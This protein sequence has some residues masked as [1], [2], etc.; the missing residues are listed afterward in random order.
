MARRV[1]PY[2]S[3]IVFLLLMCMAAQP[4]TGQTTDS[5]EVKALGEIAE[6]LGKK[7]WNT[8]VCINDLS[9]L[10]P[11]LD[12]RP[13]DNNS[14]FCNC[15]YPD[16]VCHVVALI[17]NRQDLGGVLPRSLVKLHYLTYLDLYGN[18]LSHNIPHEWASTKLEIL[19][20]SVNNL[21]GPIPS[22]LGNITTLRYMNIENNLFSGMVPL[23]L[24][25]LVNLEHL[26]L[27]ANNLSG[28]LPVAL[29]KLTKLTELRISS[30]NFT[31][32]MP[33]FF[34]SWKQLE[35]LEIQASGF[36]GPIPPSI[37]I[38][39]N[40]TEL[41]ISDLVGGD[42]KFPNLGSST[43]MNR[44]M[45]KSC[46]I[47][48]P[49]PPSILSMTQ[50]QTLDLSFNR[51]DGIIPYFGGLTKLTYLCLTS[52]LLTGSVPDWI[53]SR[54]S[55]YQID[56]SYNN[57]SEGSAPTCTDNINFFKSFSGRDKLT[58]RECLD[59]SPCQ[60]DWYS[61][62]INC[63]GKATKIGNIN[64]EADVD[65]AGAAKY[66][67]VR[68]YWGFS[69]SGRFWDVNTT[70]NDYIANNVSVLKMNES[71]LYTS[72]RLSP[73][74]ITYYARCLANGTYKLKLHFAE[75]VIR[76]NRSFYSL[77]RRIF[78]IYVQEKLVLKD[79]DIENAAPGVDKAVVREYKAN[80]TNKVLMIRFF[81][82]G[83][84]TTTAPTRGTYGPLISAI[85]VEADFSLPDDGKMKISIVVGAV[86]VVLLLI[87]MILGILWWKG[88]LGGRKSR[89]NELKGLDLQ[90][91][92]F[93]YRQIKAATNNFDAA[94]KLGEGGFGSVYKGILSDGTVI[95]VKQLSSKSRQGSREFV[96]EIGMI[97]GLQHPNLV[98]LYGCCVEGKQ[99]LL[100]YEYMENNSLARALF[101]PADSW[102]KLD[103]LA[104]QK[105][106]VGI[107]KGLAFLHEE[108]TLKIVHRDIKSTNVLLDRD[109]NPKISDFGLAKLDEEEN[110]HIST[111]IAGTIGYMAPEYALWGHLTYKADVYSFGVV[112][113]EIIAGKNN[114][115]YQ[116]NQN[117]ICLLDWA[118]VLQ[119]RGDLMELVDPEMGSDFSKEEALRMIKVAL[120]CTNPSPVLRPVMTAVVNMLEGRIVIDELTRGPGIYG[121]EW[122]FEALRDQY[123]ESS[124]PNSM[125]SQS[126]VQSSNATWI[127]SSSTPAHNIYS[128]NQNE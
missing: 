23:E 88:C 75:I 56:L 91:G 106:C 124:R 18:F 10:T 120:L 57:L 117:F 90:T 49:I 116:P 86:V 93:T 100:V 33:D 20:L 60:K 108:S 123:G 51:L 102:L 40:L 3:F 119:Q 111:R 94:N 58:L 109:L 24:G 96:N 22:F 89:E 50:L 122:G 9:W 70:A 97:S 112:A 71:E 64:Y 12:S 41:R 128:T 14:L 68:E 79:F 13:P 52:N 98:R 28:E 59:E 21:S 6:Q 61:V 8:N 110:T 72:A 17:L 77:G 45:L 2:I 121:N 5:D 11:K 104:R 81:W 105:I 114:M 95:A 101:G 82:A 103:W 38:L 74:S 30:N 127:G 69:S 84:G 34:E 107:A 4:G 1:L 73:L 63:G 26:I 92:Y 25:K 27:S 48:G 15:S 115:K 118:I 39:S 19:S 99:L 32:R 35:K 62:H 29:T 31:G 46:N 44:L 43:R 66:V 76:D 85:S 53:T 125:E 67:H 65:P 54:D 7:D 78:D 113:L 36:E 37:S 42:S 16:S 47:S 83:K 126:L 55:K 87:F 80:V